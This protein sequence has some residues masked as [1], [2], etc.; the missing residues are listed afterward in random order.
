VAAT[1]DTRFIDVVN[2]ASQTTTVLAPYGTIPILRDPHKWRDWASMVV[3]LPA[4]S[5]LG[6]PRPEGFERWEDWARQFN[7]AARLLVT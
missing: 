7:F 2:W 5:A 4:L 3:S 6:A 1:I